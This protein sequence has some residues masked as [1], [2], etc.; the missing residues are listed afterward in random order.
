ML[1]Y[2]YMSLGGYLQVL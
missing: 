1:N 2:L